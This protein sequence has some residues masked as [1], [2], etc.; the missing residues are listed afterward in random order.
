MRAG[1]GRASHSSGVSRPGKLR[2]P[3]GRRRGMA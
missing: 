3:V 2:G 1:N